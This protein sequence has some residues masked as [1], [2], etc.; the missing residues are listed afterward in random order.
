MQIIRHDHAF[1][2]AS[3]FHPAVSVMCWLIGAGAGWLVFR[4]SEPLFSSLMRGVLLEPVSIVGLLMVSFLP[5][6]ITA[7]AVLY[8][9]PFAIHV[10]S[11][12]KGLVSFVCTL[13]VFG[14]FNRAGWLGRIL[15]LFS[16][17]FT[18]VLLF[19]LWFRIF[20]LDRSKL[21]KEMLVSM[22]LCL[23]IVG[24][25]VLLISPFVWLLKI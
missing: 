20:I 2:Q 16:D 12:S 8:S 22:V 17:C 1:A 3:F 25:D 19:V 7:V 18:T 4:Q 15:F 13:S 24:L 6:I 23:T 14:V 21:R 5:F 9:K 10:L 11:F